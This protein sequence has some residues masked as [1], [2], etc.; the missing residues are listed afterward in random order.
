M[1][2]EQLLLRFFQ[3]VAKGLQHSDYNH[4][5]AKNTKYMQL[6]AGVG[7][8]KLLKQYVR[9]E[10]DILFEQRVALTNHIVTAVCSNLLDYFHKVP[11]SNSARRVLTYTGDGASK[12]TDEIEQVLSKFSGTDSFDD[13]M[14]T[15]YIDLISTDPNAFVVIEWDSFDSDRELIQP[16]PYIVLSPEAI[17]YAYNNKVL[18]YLISVDDHVYEVATPIGLLQNDRLN[19]DIGNK[20][21]KKYTLYGKNQTW[22]LRQVDEDLISKPSVRNEGDIIVIAD[23][24]YVKLGKYYFELEAYMPHNCGQVPAFRVGYKRDKATSGRT[25]VNQLHAC[26]PYLEKTIKVNSELDLVATLLAMPQ[27]VSYG[28]SCVD[29]NCYNGYYSDETVCKSCHG[30]GVRPTASSSQDAIRIKMPDSKE[31]MIPLS[32]IIKYIHPPVEIVKWQEEYIEKL[33]IKAKAIMFN[34]DPIKKD[35][36]AKTATGENIDMQNVYDALHPFAVRFGKLWTYGVQIMAKL[37]SREEGLIAIYSFGKDF[38]LKS[39]DS[40]V[41]DLSI[42]NSIGNPNLIRHLNDDVAQIIFA[43]KPLE[44]QR[45]KIKEMYNPFTGKTE[46]EIMVLLM[47]DLVLKR[48]KVLHAN[49]GIIFD[50]LE[51]DFASQ[52]KD[53]YLLNRTEQRVAIYGKVEDIMMMLK[54]DN[55]PPVPELF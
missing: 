14:A 40:L 48:D 53:F 6:V 55:P 16:K 19:P 7:L 27:Q 17:D 54:Q 5:V 2:N 51:I 45:Y 50:E 18:E 44:H 9:R 41:I 10:T 36:A 20:K 1:D 22:Q 25:Y 21:G 31:Q 3:V 28:Q 52:G 8:G 38:K 32:E 47:S 37:A 39:L 29:E 26:Q 49:Y 42:A 43:E 24:T 35:Q 12:K 46:K 33:T 11:R 13:F 15:E 4:V 30:E 23:K 34:S